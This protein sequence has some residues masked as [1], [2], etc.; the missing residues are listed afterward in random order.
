MTKYKNTRLIQSKKY[1]KSTSLKPKSHKQA[2]NMAQIFR[3]NYFYSLIP[4]T[5][6]VQSRG[7]SGFISDTKQTQMSPLRL[8]TAS[9]LSGHHFKVKQQ[10]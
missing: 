7:D 6:I 10:E 8:P 9:G 3:N 5:K 1:K 4:D 2:R